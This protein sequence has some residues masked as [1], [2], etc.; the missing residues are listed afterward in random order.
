MAAHV[1]RHWLG[2][3]R[4]YCGATENVDGFLIGLRCP[5]HTPAAVAGRPEPP[6]PGYTPPGA[7][8]R[9]PAAPSQAIHSLD[10]L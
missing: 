5:L 9:P 8:A 6:G 1:C 7:P 4:R 10:L 2:T 3:E